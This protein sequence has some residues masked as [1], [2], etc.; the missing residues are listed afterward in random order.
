[1]FGG[2]LC[3]LPVPLSKHYNRQVGDYAS[4]HSPFP[5]AKIGRRAGMASAPRIFGKWDFF[6]RV[7]IILPTTLVLQVGPSRDSWGNIFGNAMIWQLGICLATEKVLAAVGCWCC[8]SPFRMQIRITA[9]QNFK[10]L[11]IS[12]APPLNRSE[13]PEPHFWRPG[14][15]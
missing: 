7:G 9:I 4:S 6:R 3:T 5:L 11:N 1:M 12:E 2:F 14:A 8:L 15:G 13:A 10:N